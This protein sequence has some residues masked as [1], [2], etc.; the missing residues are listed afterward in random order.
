MIVISPSAQAEPA[1]SGTVATAAIS[2]RRVIFIMVSLPWLIGLS[3]WRRLP[4]R[5]P[6]PRGMVAGVTPCAAPL[7]YWSEFIS[8]ASTMTAPVKTVCQ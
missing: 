6:W 4:R 1:I 3:R 8:T 5:P 7:P 2:I